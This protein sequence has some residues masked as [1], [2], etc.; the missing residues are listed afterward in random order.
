MVLRIPGN[1]T[2]SAR[3]S[4]R[5]LEIH[6]TPEGYTVTDISK[7][8]TLH[9]G[10]PLVSGIAQPL[11]SGD[12]LIVAGVITLEVLLNGIRNAAL[13]PPQIE[14]AV[15]GKWDVPLVFEASVGDMV[16]VE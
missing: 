15:T 3:I 5:H 13:A 8:G 11:R 6:H 1:E 9:N 14:V 2:L 16:T 7:A 12:L 10:R 4:R